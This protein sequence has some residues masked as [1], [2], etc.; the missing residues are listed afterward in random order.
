M[1]GRLLLVRVMRLSS[2]KMFFVFFV[3]FSTYTVFFSPKKTFYAETCGFV[4]FL[5]A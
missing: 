4:C 2:L 5:P 3:F 1:P